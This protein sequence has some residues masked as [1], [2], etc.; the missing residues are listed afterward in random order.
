MFDGGV[1]KVICQSVPIFV[2]GKVHVWLACWVEFWP[3]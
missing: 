2:L 3:S 1:Q